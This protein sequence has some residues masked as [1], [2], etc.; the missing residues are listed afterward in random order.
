MWAEAAEKLKQAAQTLEAIEKWTPQGS[1]EHKEAASLRSKIESYI[2]TAEK[3]AMARQAEA[4]EQKPLIAFIPPSTKKEPLEPQQGPRDE[5]LGDEQEKN[6]MTARPS[7]Q[8]A[9]E[10]PKGQ[11]PVD[12]EVQAILNLQ[13]AGFQR[14]E[15]PGEEA[16]QPAQPAKPAETPAAPAAPVAQPQEQGGEKTPSEITDADLEMIDQAVEAMTKE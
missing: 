15:A 8:G 5:A 2:R 13:L 3:K 10:H 9:P 4:P 6:A 7:S 1:E 11:D 12:P 16:A 14:I